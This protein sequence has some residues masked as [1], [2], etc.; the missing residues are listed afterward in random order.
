MKKLFILS[1]ALFGIA[2]YAQQDGRVGINT[3]E[4]KAT[5]QVVGK[6]G[7]KEAPDGVQLPRLTKAELKEKTAYGTEQKGAMVYVYDASGDGNDATAGVTV[8]CIYVFDGSKWNNAGCGNATVD[9]TEYGIGCGPGPYRFNLKGKM[10]I[11]NYEYANGQGGLYH[12]EATET[13]FPNSVVSIGIGSFENNDLGE[14]TLPEHLVSIGADAFKNAKLKG[15]VTLPPTVAYIGAG[16]FE[17]NEITA[18][19]LPPDL[20]EIS[21]NTFANNKLTEIVIPERVKCI[22]ESA[23]ENNQLAT[24]TIPNSVECIMDAAFKNNQLTQINLPKPDENNYPPLYKGLTELGPEAF[25]DNL[26]Q[27]VAI[28][29]SL[30]EIPYMAFFNNKLTSVEFQPGILQYIRQEAFAQNLIAGEFKAPANLAVIEGGAFAVNKLTKVDL[31]KLSG[32]IG[33]NVFRYNEITEVIFSKTLTQIPGGAF[34]DNK[35]ADVRQK[36]ATQGKITWPTADFSILQGAFVNNEFNTGYIIYMPDNAKRLA[37]G[38]F[39]RKDNTNVAGASIKSGTKY[40]DTGNKTFP[41]NGTPTI[42]P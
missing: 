8:P 26:L 6:P 1:L 38:V 27:S 24:A 21:A 13:C 28:P 23:F 15:Q 39:T 17:G 9:N 36:T 34:A 12:P 4:P 32:T 40:V 42:R 37:G 14:I 18:V 11:A 3:E 7:V 2:A 29:S 10:Q 5:L 25:R 22:R 31:S 30:R 19:N 41:I 35:I 16:A 20:A 33:E